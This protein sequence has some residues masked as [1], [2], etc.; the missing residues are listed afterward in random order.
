MNITLPSTGFPLSDT[1]TFAVTVPIVFTGVVTSIVMFA[2]RFCIVSVPVTFPALYM[3]F[4]PMFTVNGYVF[5]PI[6]SVGST[7]FNT[8]SV[9]VVFIV[10]PFISIV[11]SFV[12]MSVFPFASFIIVF[13]V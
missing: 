10:C 8:P 11:T 1:V 7:M 9:I 5:A 3:L 13:I 12:P 4:S 6:L 2:S